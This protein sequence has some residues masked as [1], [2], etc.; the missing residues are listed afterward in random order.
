M[1]IVGILCLL[2]ASACGQTGLIYDGGAG[3]SASQGDGGSQGDGSQS[4]SRQGF[5]TLQSH[6][7]TGCWNGNPCAQDQYNWTPINGQTFNA[8]NE[9]I[10]CSGTT[11]RVA[12]VGIGTYQSQL[13]CQ[14]TWDVYCDSNKVG[15]LSTL[16][17]ACA[18]SAMSNGC[19]ISF[20]PVTC[21]TIKLVATA[22]SGMLGCCGASPPDSMIV[23]VSAW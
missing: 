4:A 1:R 23:A 22:G 8:I 3:G 5:N 20:A 16:N 17:K 11:A 13:Q 2:G 12:H 21:S 7:T 6:T 19:S 18:D 14:G 15:S 9:N 10:V